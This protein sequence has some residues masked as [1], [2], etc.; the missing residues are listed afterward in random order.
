MHCDR[1]FRLCVQ[2]QWAGQRLLHTK[3]REKVVGTALTSFV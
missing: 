1:C 3:P 2:P